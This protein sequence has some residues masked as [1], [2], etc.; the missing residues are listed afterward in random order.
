MG[1][2]VHDVLKFKVYITL[3]LTFKKK[4]FLVQFQIIIIWKNET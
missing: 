4:H 3:N 1:Y 2:N